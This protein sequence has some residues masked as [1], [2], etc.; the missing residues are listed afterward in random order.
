[1]TKVLLREPFVQQLDLL[2]RNLLWQ[3]VERSKARHGMRVVGGRPFPRKVAVIC[4]RIG[5]ASN[6]GVLGAG[7]IGIGRTNRCGGW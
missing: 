7:S 3:I 6:I 1:M 4:M 2:Q 5:A